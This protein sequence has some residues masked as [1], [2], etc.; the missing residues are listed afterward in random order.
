MLD[1][2][3]YPALGIRR[4]AVIEIYSNAATETAADPRCRRLRVSFV[5]SG[6]YVRYFAKVLRLASRRVKY[7]Q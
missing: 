6:T 7:I 3:C 2:A 5:Y 1:F 4:H